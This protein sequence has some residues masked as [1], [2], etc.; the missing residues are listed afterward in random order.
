[1]CFP[2]FEE[3]DLAPLQIRFDRI[4]VAESSFRHLQREHWQMENGLHYWRDDR[5]KEDY[6]L[7]WTS[8]AAPAMA[9]LNSLILGLR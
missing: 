3:N 5:L 4:T 6:S 1:M 2:S 7:L 8:H 9:V